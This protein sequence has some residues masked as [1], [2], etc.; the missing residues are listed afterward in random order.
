MTEI[1]LTVGEL[2]A[3]FS[4]VLQ[5]VQEGQ[6]V[7]VLYGRAKKPVANITAITSDTLLPRPLGL[8]EGKASFKMAD[9][10]KFKSTEDFLGL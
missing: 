2:K 1:A 8:L 6:T 7:Q 4:E 5:R 3:G 9:G 10:F